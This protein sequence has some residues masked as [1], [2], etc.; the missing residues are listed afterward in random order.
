[1]KIQIPTQMQDFANKQMDR[2][3]F[4]RHTAAIALFVVGGGM[5]AQSL[6]RLQGNTRRPQAAEPQ[7]SQLAYG[8]SAYGGTK[9]KV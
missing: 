3:E 9:T 4:L 8:G 7:P 1:M 5:I 6:L 2:K